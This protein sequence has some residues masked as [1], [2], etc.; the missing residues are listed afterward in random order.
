MRPGLKIYKNLYKK[1][2]LRNLSLTDQLAATRSILA[3]ERTFLSYQRSALTI[4]VAGLTLIKFFDWFWIV[5]IG[6]LFLP[7]SVVFVIIGTVRYRRM[8][9]L[10]LSLEDDSVKRIKKMNDMN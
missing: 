5:V 6:W 1:F 4:A 7:A 2:I 10:I 8:L 9:T 3:N